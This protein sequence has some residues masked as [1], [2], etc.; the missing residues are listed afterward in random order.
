M[1]DD[2]DDGYCGDTD[3]EYVDVPHDDADADADVAHYYCQ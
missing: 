1:E 2:I 3:S